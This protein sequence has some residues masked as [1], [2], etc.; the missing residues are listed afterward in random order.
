MKSIALSVGLLFAL[1]VHADDLVRAKLVGTR[2]VSSYPGA[3]ILVCKYLGPE[4]K[5]EVVASADRCAPTFELS[6]DEAVR[7]DDAGVSLARTTTP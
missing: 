6:N 1:S 7:I 4:A 3:P 2:T 5:Y